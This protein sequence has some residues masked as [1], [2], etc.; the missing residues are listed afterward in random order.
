[1]SES[2]IKNLVNPS[3]L[4]GLYDGEPP[5]EGFLLREIRLEERGPSC[6]IIGEM[7]RFPEHPRGAWATDATILEVRLSLT[8]IDDFWM[9]GG[10]FGTLV[11][12]EIT[13]NDDGFGVTVRGDGDDM[14]FLVSG[15]SFQV[16]GMRAHS[17]LEEEL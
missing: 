4:E 9:R 7:P 11:D 2:W 10:A 17:G 16:I 1:M 13:R 8:L 15:V 6:F 5:L 12:L 3:A 14:E